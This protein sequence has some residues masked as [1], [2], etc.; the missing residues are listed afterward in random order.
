VRAPQV[1]DER[2]LDIRQLIASEI[3]AMHHYQ[4]INSRLSSLGFFV[5][6]PS[7]FEITRSSADENDGSIRS[8]QAVGVRTDHKRSPSFSEAHRDAVSAVV[9]G[10]GKRGSGEIEQRERRVR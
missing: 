8:S 5:L 7:L 1:D 2:L 6:L 3:C 10:L 4:H 9:S